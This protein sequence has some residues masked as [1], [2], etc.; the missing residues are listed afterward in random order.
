MLLRGKS[1]FYC[2]N[3]VKSED[4]LK[5]KMQKKFLNAQDGS[6]GSNDILCGDK[7]RNGGFLY[8]WLNNF[9]ATQNV[10]NSLTSS[11]TSGL[12]EQLY[13]PYAICLA[14]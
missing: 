5:G 10:R 7:E 14:I 8:N 9:R 3:R 4:T 1:L 2:E 6:T 13:Y 12:S 11:T